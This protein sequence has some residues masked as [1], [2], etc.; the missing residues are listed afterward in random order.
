MPTVSNTTLTLTTVGANTTLDVTFDTEF[1]EVERN[2]VPLGL[3]YHVHGD[4]VGVDGS[5]ETVLLQ[6]AFPHKVIPVT[7]GS[8]P[9]LLS[10]SVSLTV[11]RADLQ[12]DT[13]G[14]EDEIRCNIRI[15]SV[16]LPPTFTENV[17]TPL[18][19]LLG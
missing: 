19:V 15:H 9:Q 10:T 8:T 16:G 7:P 3:I 1:N 11:P 17:P 2:L 13:G 12:E 5:T 14:D 4:V 18:K 6:D